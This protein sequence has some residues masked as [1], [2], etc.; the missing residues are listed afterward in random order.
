MISKPTTPQILQTI[1]AELNDKI[2]PVLT[3]PTHVVAVQMMSAMLDAL[4]VRTENEL[5]WMRDECDSVEAAASSYVEAHPDATAVA[6][7]LAEYRD[8]T[9]GSLRLSDV[10]ADYDRAT[11]VLSRMAEAVFG[12]GTPAEV[13]TVEQLIEQRLATELAIVGTFVAAGRE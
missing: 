8:H 10:Q 11:E 13:R 7:A 3:D 6:T 9:G 1:K 4:C 12:H 5:A 2:A